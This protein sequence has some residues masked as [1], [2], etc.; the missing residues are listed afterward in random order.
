MISLLLALALLP[1]CEQKSRPRTPPSATELAPV[2]A[3]KADAEALVRDLYAPYLD[4][5]G[6][7]GLERTGKL[8]ASLQA[9]WEESAKRAAAL[10]EPGPIDHDPVVAGQDWQ[11]TELSLEVSKDGSH[12][13]VIARFK[14]F[15][16][17]TTVTWKLIG[18]GSV[19]RVD[20]V[21]PEGSSVREEIR[22]S[23]TPPAGP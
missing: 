17:P 23:L 16:R 12:A 13:T 20:D 15:D 14:N 11:I 4:G 5:G 10:G 3:T 6:G 7:P 18:E 9:I 2:T 8:S 19:W 1:A 22:R 21:Q